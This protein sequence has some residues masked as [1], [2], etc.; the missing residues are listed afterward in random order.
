[1]R[2]AKMP[3]VQIRK[4]AFTISRSSSPIVLLPIALL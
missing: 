2:I 1:M 4:A 3:E